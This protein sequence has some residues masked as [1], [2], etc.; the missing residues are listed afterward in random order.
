MREEKDTLGK[1][2][3]REDVYYGIQT[4]RAVE[5]FPVSGLKESEELINSYVELKKACALTNMDLDVLDEE[6]GRLIVD[7]CDDILEGG[8]EDQFPVDVFQA[9]AGT[10]FNM[11]VNEV[12][13]N[14]ALEIVGKEKG[15]Y[16]FIHPNDHVNM[17]QSSNDTFPTASH[18]AIIKAA[19]KLIKI[20]H[21]L[22][23]AFESKGKDFSDV[24]KSGR[25]HLMDATPV[26]LG[27]EFLAYAS[28][29]DRAAKRIKEA[30]N[31]LL[32]LPIGGTAVGTGVN[33]PEGFRKKV[34][35]KL[36]EIT[37][38]D[39]EEARNSFELIHSRSQMVEFSGTLKELALELTRIANDI[40]LLSSGPL[41][42]LGE[43]D[44]P[45][46]QPGSSIMPGKI[47]PVMAECL[48][49][50]CF[51]IIGKDTTVSM[52]GQAGQLEM[53]VMVPVITYNI[54]DSISLL[55]NY[56]PVL[57]V[58]CIEGIKANEEKCREYMELSPSLAT[59]LSPKNGYEKAAEIAEE[60]IEKGIPIPELV[61]E[62]GIM[63]QEEA[64]ELFDPEKLADNKYRE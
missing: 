22:A 28:S 54:L 50:I 10:S 60:S 4:V 14:R 7:A 20:L 47:N 26:T 11:N 34:I 48:N 32:E 46:V 53:N 38:Y 36:S 23:D 19:D 55:N 27:D 9:G 33:T 40:R 1:M 52:A 5:N 24:Q 39:F 61:V 13:A 59:V 44:L 57:Q 12:I 15:K 31:D 29:I 25:T 58:K 35:K 8:Y 17:S 6:K 51:Q 64:D 3:V 21:N 30:R 62:K 49:M 16:E 2:D 37:G 63:T 45:K 42:G 41:T 56:L 18:I 43:I